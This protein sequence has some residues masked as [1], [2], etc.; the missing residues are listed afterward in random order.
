MADDATTF[1]FLPV[2]L[3]QDEKLKETSI[4]V[5]VL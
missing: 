3:V 2:M 5:N 4:D 1:S